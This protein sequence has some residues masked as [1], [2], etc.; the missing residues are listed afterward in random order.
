MC[1]HIPRLTGDIT[2]LSIND[3]VTYLLQ[4]RIKYKKS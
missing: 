1:K 3:S 2:N 4:Y